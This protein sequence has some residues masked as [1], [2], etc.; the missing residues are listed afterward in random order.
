MKLLKRIVLVLVVLVVAAFFARNFIA[1]KAVE[2]GAKQMT[3][4]PLEIGSVNL[5]LFNGTLEVHDLKLLNPPEFHGGVFVDLPVFKVDYVTL[6][7]L[8]GAPHIKELTVNVEQVVLVKNEKGETNADVLQAKV[9]PPAKA[10]PKGEQPAKE[11]PPAKETKKAKY[12]V[13]LV[14]LHVGSVVRK[15]YAS[16]G[17]P[18][19]K[20]IPLNQDIKITNLNE[21]TSIT[22]IIMQA[23][24]GPVGAVAGDLVKGV[25]DAVKG[26]GDAAKGVTDSVGKTG[27]GLF[28]SIKKAVPQ[29]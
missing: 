25:G 27:K 2:I 28:D 29:K 16:G 6:S 14:Q 4:F 17:Q 26:V 10:Q 20:K 9:S 7:M 15:V 19:E 13:D 8:S 3:G 5:G 1:R 23:T 24:L 22:A 11:A 12:Q 21:S 18:S